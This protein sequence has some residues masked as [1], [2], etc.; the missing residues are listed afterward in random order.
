M[1]DPPRLLADTFCKYIEMVFVTRLIG[2]SSA[3]LLAPIRSC[4]RA[5]VAIMLVSKA[6]LALVAACV[7]EFVCCEETAEARLLSA[8]NTTRAVPGL[9]V[10]VVASTS[11]ET[12]LTESETPCDVSSLGYEVIALI[13]PTEALR[14][15]A[16]TLAPLERVLR[17]VATAASTR[18]CRRLVRSSV[19]A[20]LEEEPP[21]VLE[22]S[23][24]RE[25]TVEI[26]LC[27]PA[28]SARR[29]LPPRLLV[30]KSRRLET[31]NDGG[32]VMIT[33]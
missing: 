7:D 28:E 30:V 24:S 8:P 17:V 4:T 27:M 16:D 3:A 33:V 12:A 18:L 11:D 14:T 26:M 32:W 19:L 20:W 9:T 21:P 29:S 22:K 23:F 2:S 1:F 31:E 10:P 15:S 13:A 25:A 5:I 6:A